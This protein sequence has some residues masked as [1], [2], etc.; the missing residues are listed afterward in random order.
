MIEYNFQGKLM[1]EVAASAFTSQ[2]TF[3]RVSRIPW[4]ED[5]QVLQERSPCGE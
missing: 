5:I 1:K 3:S 4:H 2:T